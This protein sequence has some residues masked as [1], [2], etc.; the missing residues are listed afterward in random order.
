[1]FLVPNDDSTPVFFHILTT[2]GGYCGSSSDLESAKLV[3]PDS[4]FGSRGK[5]R[6]KYRKK[7]SLSNKLFHLYILKIIFYSIFA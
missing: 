7:T 3:D 6:S 4:D 5:K 2:D 1:V